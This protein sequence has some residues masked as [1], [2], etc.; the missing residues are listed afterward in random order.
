V[1]ADPPSG[2]RV[3]H[4]H[5]VAAADALL[6]HE[7][8]ADDHTPTVVLRLGRPHA[9][10]VLTQWLAASGAITVQVAASD[11]WIDPDGLNDV[12][13]V[14]EPSSFCTVLADRLRG[15]QGTPWL[16]RW[17]R[18]ESRAQAAID[19]WIDAQPHIT[20]P[21]VARA[22]LAALGDGSSLVV[23]S[24]M[25]VRDVEWY[26]APRRGVNVFANRGA[27]GIDGVT[28]TAVGVALAS[29]A[30]TTLLIGDVAFLHDTNGL[31][32]AAARGVDLTV[33]VVDNDGGGIFS[34]LPQAQL[35]PVERFEQLFGTPHGVDIEGLARAHSVPAETI[36]APDA[37]RKA[38]VAEHKGLR[39][40][41][42][43]TNR[44]ANVAAHDRLHGAVRDAL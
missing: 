11:A 1:L 41:R 6:R 35:L 12:T 13:V 28:S 31:L 24:S 42:V 21:F 25:P 5:T 29:G 3:P 16:A 23:S 44:A 32:G 40:L 7:A 39:V 15:G 2:C 36:D 19:E 30:P 14:A 43:V 18:A 4:P 10:K 22:T 38:L 8:F 26:G 34:F 27:N 17:R 37:F 9:S 20:E 33:V